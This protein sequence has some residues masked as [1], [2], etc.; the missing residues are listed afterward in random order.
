MTLLKKGV[1]ILNQSL[2]ILRGEKDKIILG[3]HPLALW[4]VEFFEN[5][6]RS[7]SFLN[8]YKEFVQ[9]YSGYEEDQKVTV[10]QW[11]SL[12]NLITLCLK[13]LLESSSVT[14]FISYEILPKSIYYLHSHIIPRSNVR[15]ERDIIY[16]DENINVL[17]LGDHGLTNNVLKKAD[18]VITK[19]D[20]ANA[21]RR[22]YPFEILDYARCHLKSRIDS[23][24]KGR[25]DV[26]VAVAGASSA[27]DGLLINEMSLKTLDLAATSEDPFH[28]MLA[29]SK[30]M[31]HC[32]NLQTVIYSCEYPILFTELSRPR[33]RGELA[34]FAQVYYPI[35]K[36]KRFFSG[37]VPSMFLRVHSDLILESL[38]N[39]E[40]IRLH[41]DNMFSK[42]LLQMPYYNDNYFKR[43]QYGWL[44][45]D[46]HTKDD[47]TNF[48]NASTM[49]IYSF[50]DNTSNLDENFILIENMLKKAQA[51]NIKVIL[52]IS[53][54][55]R[56]SKRF[57]QP[58]E[59]TMIDA[60]LLPLQKKYGFQLENLYES[61]LFTDEDFADYNHLNIKGAK[62]YTSFLSSLIL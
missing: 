33:E 32:V 22:C 49:P 58:K 19:K 37:E 30:T 51:K 34:T 26:K 43:M 3:L 25:P 48:R 42:N 45:F 39:F 13:E 29:L 11:R 59:K 15:Y 9:I 46:F 38:F 61:D 24:E 50:C 52:C 10:A 36:Q 12:E 28:A 55:S 6:N 35:F 20:I 2:N 4:C 31:D 16:S 7:D 21:A 40:S 1:L 60:R 53:P 18:I 56:F 23:L 41:E 54:Y 17:L 14:L 57:C 44:S 5:E 27:R 8:M 62:K 47:D